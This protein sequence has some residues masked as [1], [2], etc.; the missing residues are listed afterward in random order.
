MKEKKKKSELHSTPRYLSSF[1]LS[2]YYYGLSVV[3]PLFFPPPFESCQRG[4]VLTSTRHRGTLIGTYSKKKYVAVTYY[5]AKCIRN[6]HTLT[7]CQV[8]YSKN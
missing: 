4:S 8:V 1:S 7:E 3:P 5:S 6:A 2:S